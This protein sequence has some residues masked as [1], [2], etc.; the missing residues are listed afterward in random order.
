MKDLPHVNVT[1]TR[2][3]NP[4]DDTS[5]LLRIDVWPIPNDIS[6]LTELMEHAR[7]AIHARL[8]AHGL[9]SPE[10]HDARTNQGVQ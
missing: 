4:S 2:L 9:T 5:A 1:A 7:A 10:W 6:L 8:T 3:Y